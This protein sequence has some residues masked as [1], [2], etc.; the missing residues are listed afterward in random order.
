MKAKML[1]IAGVKSEK[2]F[3][4]K[5]PSE[6]AFMKAHGEAFKKAQIGAYIGGEQGAGFQPV[7]FKDVYDQADYAVTGSTDDQR[8]EDA[9]RKAELAAAQKQPGGG[10]GGLGASH[11]PNVTPGSGTNGL[12][13]GGGGSHNSSVGTNGSGGSGVVIVRFSFTNPT[14]F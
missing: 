13:G 12:G 11:S 5:Y 9:Y 2:E 6:E 10:G 14:S 8:K 4:K 1:K 7:N 3:Y